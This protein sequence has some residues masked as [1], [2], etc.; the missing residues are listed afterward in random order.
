MTMVVVTHE[1]RFAR[2]VADYVVVME[3]GRIIDSGPARSVL[4]SPE[5]PRTREFL[6]RV[7]DH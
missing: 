6:H 4:T 7:L 2:D 3:Q 5:N 1:I